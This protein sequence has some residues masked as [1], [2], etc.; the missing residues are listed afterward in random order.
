MVVDDETSKVEGVSVQ[1]EDCMYR[2]QH[3]E[4]PSEQDS[5][6]WPNSSSRIVPTFFT[7]YLPTTPSSTASFGIVESVAVAIG[8]FVILVL[9]I[10]AKLVMRVQAWMVLLSV[11]EILQIR[12]LE[13]IAVAPTIKMTGTLAFLSHNTMSITSIHGRWSSNVRGYCGV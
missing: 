1:Q 10:S 8:M 9:T 4:P 13:F 6:E 3:E 12:L 11:D 5:Y 7:R 2:L